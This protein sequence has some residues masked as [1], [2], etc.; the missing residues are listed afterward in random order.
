[1]A[2][3]V[4]LRPGRMPAITDVARLA[5]V[6]HQTVSRVLNDHPRV[7]AETR[8]RVVEAISTLGYRRNH[9]A[10]ALVTGQSELLGVVAL[11]TLLFGPVSMLSA[12]EE[13]ADDNGFVVSVASV[14]SFEPEEVKRAV[15]RL[16]DQSV[17]G[18]IMIVPVGLARH[19]LDE[20]PAGVPYVVIDG[21]LTRDDPVATVDQVTGGYLATKHLL[22]AG[23]ETVW[24]VRGPLE[25][26]DS[27]GRIEGWQR[28]L[29]ERGVEAPPPVAGDWTPA[30][31]YLAGKVLA[32]D[33]SVTAVFVANDHMALGFLRAMHEVGRRV[34]EDV[35]V[36]GFDDIPEAEFFLPRLTTVRPDFEGAA[37]EGLRLLLEQIGAP[38]PTGQTRRSVLPP[39]LVERDSVAPPRV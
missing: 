39:S 35:S 1:M 27:Q 32:A 2:A 17:A 34:P 26:H 20:F 7:R 15:E 19:A 25:W 24:H 11:G 23:H 36:V 9:A 16:L 4:P 6:S 10:R 38:V 18:V 33:P 12:V 22:D 37:R 31:G 8:Q 14:R 5:G 13:L 28:A 21:D 3:P 30:S 29:R